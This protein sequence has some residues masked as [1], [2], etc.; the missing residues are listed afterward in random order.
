MGDHPHVS[1][2]GPNV[3]NVHF[4]QRTTYIS[5]KTYV[6]PSRVGP[7]VAHGT[8]GETRYRPRAAE[9]STAADAWPLG[10]QVLPRADSEHAAGSPD[11]DRGGR[12]PSG[13]LCSRGR[14]ID[15]GASEDE[16]RSR[17]NGAAHPNDDVGKPAARSG[18]APLA[19]RFALV[20]PPLTGGGRARAALADRKSE[21]G[22]PETRGRGR[23]LTPSE[24]GDSIRE[25]LEDPPGP[26][27]PH[28]GNS[29]G[30]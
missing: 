6:R 14:A 4:V 28:H 1:L 15:T 17:R 3:H 5:Y 7:D 18:H 12:A 16:A 23:T 29:R 24:R 9:G 26:T 2:P 21:E 20:A 19:A 10:G 8:E 30:P 22:Y 27:Q 11:D 25:R 13:W